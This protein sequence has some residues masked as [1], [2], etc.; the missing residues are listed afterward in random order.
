VRVARVRR[1]EFVV[2]ACVGITFLSS[3][4]VQR[5]VFP[6]F[7]GNHDEP[8]YALQAEALRQ[9]RLNL[10][11]GDASVRE[12]LQP[13]L[14]GF[15][16]GHWFTVYPPGVPALLAGGELLGSQ[17]LGV[18]AAAALTVVAAYAFAFEVLRSRRTAVVAMA[19]ATLSPVFLIQSGLR[20]SYMLAIASGLLFAAAALRG[21]RTDS[22]RTLILAGAALGVVVVTR[23]FDALLWSLPIVV[24]MGFTRRHE[25][26]R[27]LRAAAAVAAGFAPFVV[28]LLAF[29]AAATGSPWPLPAE[30]AEPLNRLGFGTRAL[31]PTSPPV[32]FGPGAALEAL[33]DNLRTVPAWAAGGFVGLALAVVGIAHLRRQPTTWLVVL[34]IAAFPAGYFFYWGTLYQAVG[35]DD[36]GPQYYLPLFWLVAVPTADALTFLWDTRRFVAV[37]AIVCA[38]TLSVAAAIDKVQANLEVTTDYQSI[39]SAVDAAALRDSVLFVPYYDD[40]YVAERYPFLANGPEPQRAQLIYAVDLGPRVIDYITAQPDRAPHRLV[41]V[42]HAGDTLLEARAEVERLELVV[43]ARYVIRLQVTNPGPEPGVVTYVVNGFDVSTRVLD[44]QSRA[45]ESY[46]TTWVITPPDAPTARGV[47]VDRGY[48]TFAVGVEFGDQARLVEGTERFELRFEYRARS[49]DLAVLEPGASARRAVL[50]S[51]TTWFAQDIDDVLRDV[52]P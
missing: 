12:F 2:A 22:H 27:L 48:S 29:T 42:R 10:P 24:V 3:L 30:A 5:E 33:W 40:P 36:L 35:A 21:L 17:R 13:W 14:T 7:S 50:A 1:S 9:G 45:G 49:G 15:H 34:L 46:I 25:P 44:T 18:A 43:G 31:M 20:L 28:M 11:A 4:V 39:A 16:D 26:R 37:V 52:S 32:D 41:R 38:L 51:G 23:P 47:A 19:I 6:Y 8:V